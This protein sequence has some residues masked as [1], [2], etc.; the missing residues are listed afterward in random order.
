MSQY[1]HILTD[2]T[3]TV[4]VGGSPKTIIR[5]HLY[6][7]QVME[8]I[9]SGER[10]DDRMRELLRP[11]EALR[12]AID[13]E[14]S[15]HLRNGVLSFCY[16]GIDIPLPV[17]IKEAIIH[18]RMNNLSVR[19]I[20]NMLCK[21]HQNPHKFVFEELFDFIT[22]AGVAITEDG[23][24]LAYKRVRYDYMDIHSGSISN[25]PGNLVTLPEPDR[26]DTDR[27]RTCSYGLHFA[28]WSYLDSYAGATC[29]RTLIVQVDP[30]DIGAIPSDYN[31]A[32]GR[33]SKYR[34]IRDITEEQE[35]SKQRIWTAADLR[36]VISE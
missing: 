16:Q 21:A 14:Y 26:L 22:A 23:D 36:A 11:I 24:L 32:K 3:L 13:G 35:L 5:D 1:P 29:N 18:C 27:H 25:A 31:N 4:I 6:F 7:D 19:P 17:T 10:N 12:S 34:I 9:N 33:A 2:T 8:L 30:R 28:A 20:Y 15:M